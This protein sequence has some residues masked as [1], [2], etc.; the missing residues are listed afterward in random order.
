MENTEPEAID[1]VVVQLSVRLEV[2]TAH[3]RAVNETRSTK[4]SYVNY[5]TELFRARRTG[6]R[7]PPLNERS[8]LDSVKL[9]ARPS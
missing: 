1:R 6:G 8:K 3:R 7:G 4:K 5:E 2:G 9:L